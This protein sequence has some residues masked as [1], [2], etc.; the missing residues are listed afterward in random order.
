[1][2]NK[3]FK[4]VISKNKILIKKNVYIRII[5]N[6]QDIELKN[7]L[8]ESSLKDSLIDHL[9]LM[10]YLDYSKFNKTNFEI[11]KNKNFVI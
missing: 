6:D 8:I 7:Q 1:M 3:R 10:N 9:Y 11:Y 5:S 2:I 4:D